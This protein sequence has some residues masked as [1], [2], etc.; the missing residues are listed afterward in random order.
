MVRSAVRVWM[1]RTTL[2][3]ALML[4]EGYLGG[5]LS[6]HPPRISGGKPMAGSEITLQ[7]H[8]YAHMS[9]SALSRVES[10]AT[11]VLLTAGIR[12]RWNA[13]L[14][15]AAQGRLVGGANA[16]IPV[17]YVYVVPA[18]MAAQL[19]LPGTPL[20][21]SLLP[22]VGDPPSRA[23][24]FYTRA[25]ET[26]QQGPAALDQLLGYAIAHEVGHL[27]LRSTAHSDWGIMRA[28]WGPEE[29]KQISQGWLHFGPQESAGMRAE[30]AARSNAADAGEEV[31]CAQTPAPP[32]GDGER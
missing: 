15:K 9:A 25:L 20:G 24:V 26:A 18:K 29:L 5:N 19:D 10:E 13:P 21:Y 11:R 7:V 28:V 17:I 31:S 3:F 30:L 14:D 16:H 8:D 4:G 23:A 27:L 12:S 2:G 32:S 6:A 22:R 1:V